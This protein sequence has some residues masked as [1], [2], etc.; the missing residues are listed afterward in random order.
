MLPWTGDPRWPSILAF[1]TFFPERMRSFQKTFWTLL[2]HTPRILQYLL[3]YLNEYLT[4]YLPWYYT[5]QNTY[6]HHMNFFNETAKKRGDPTDRENFSD[7]SSSPRAIYLV[8]NIFR[9]KIDLILIN[10]LDLNVKC[11]TG[12]ENMSGHCLSRGR[13]E[14]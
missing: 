6:D 13:F 1:N 11:F 8:P 5:P 2:S 9:P 7:L 10:T 12:N 4:I 14:I 3:W